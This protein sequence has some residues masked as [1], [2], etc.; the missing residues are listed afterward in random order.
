MVKL[1]IASNT[2]R[3]RFS[4]L[5]ACQIIK[6]SFQA[7]YLKNIKILINPMSDGGDD[8]LSVLSYYVPIKMKKYHSINP[9]NSRI[10]VNIGIYNKK[11]IIEFAEITGL[12]TIK[13][14]LT[15]LVS[16]SRGA[17]IIINKLLDD[18]FRNFIFFLG[19]S[20]IVDAGLGMMQELGLRLLDSNKNEISA[21]NI[22]KVGLI[23]EIVDNI[24]IRLKESKIRAYC[25][26]ENKFI[27]VGGNSIYFKQKG[28]TEIQHIQ[29]V[30]KAQK[31][32]ISLLGKKG[33]SIT[34]LKYGASN[35]G[36]AAT[37]SFFLKV[38]LLSGAT[39]FSK[40]S[41]IKKKIK[42]ADYVI[43]GEG[44]LDHTTL[45]GKAPKIVA[46][47]AKMGTKTAIAIVGK[48]DLSDN[49]R[50]FDY[51]IEVPIKITDN[52]TKNNSV[53]LFK[54]AIM[55]SAAYLKIKDHEI[56]L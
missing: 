6:Y 34:S 38:K 5:K 18:G 50:L 20:A 8:S 33:A 10:S 41:K 35:G 13:S 37:I 21:I 24:D 14:K 26:V 31:N 25:D 9:Q 55:K 45:F 15:P 42:H 36:M 30:S 4:A 32:Y 51:I 2:F 29:I 40:I 7:L 1:L 28:L 16:T 23:K 48:N 54:T 43:T 19:G 44:I 12:K 47:H 17:G 11:A 3:Q 49:I 39:F 52:I 46:D 56:T 27:G 22:Q 53:K